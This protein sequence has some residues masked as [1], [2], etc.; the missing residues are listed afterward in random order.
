[1]SK[2][3]DDDIVA[4]LS[5]AAG[6][7]VGFGESRLS[8]E[9]EKV[10]KAYEGQTPERS[11]PGDSPY[12]SLDV[13]EAVESMRAQLL[14][15]ASAT[16]RPITFKPAMGEDPSAAET[17]TDWCNHVVFDLNEGFSLFQTILEDGLMNR[18]GIL[19]CYW[20]SI[21]KTETYDLTNTTME[22][23]QAHMAQDP[24]VEIEDYEI[25]S[26]GVAL[27]RVRLTKKSDRSQIRLEA[28]APEEFGIAPMAKD[29]KS[30]DCFHRRRMSINQL[31]DAGYDKD[32]VEALQSDERLWE[33]T[34]SDRY[35]RFAPTDDMIGD[36]STGGVGGKA[37]RKCMVTEGYTELDLDDTGESRLYKITWAGTTLLDK[38]PVERKPFLAFVPLPRSHAFWGSNYAQMVMQTQNARTYLTRSIINHGLITNNPRLAVVRGA[39]LNPRELMENRIGGIV[40][41]TRPDGIVPIPQQGLN[42]FIFQTIQLVGDDKEQLT[43]ISRL[44]QGLNK[45]A[46]S[47]QNSQGMVNDLVNLS[48]TRQKVIAR[49]FV[50]R[51]L[52][53]LYTQIYMLTL[54]NEDRKKIMEQ[55][56]Q[57]VDV[58][59][60]AWPEDANTEVNTSLGAAARQQEVQKWMVLDKTLSGDPGLAPMYPGAKRFAVIKRAMEASGIRNV[61]D[62]LLTPDQVPP[63][64]PSPMDLADLEVKKADAAVKR[65]NADAAVKSLELKTTVAADKKAEFYAKLQMAGHKDEVK[66]Q[67]EQDKLAH[68]VA[69]DAANL[70]LALQ[71]MEAGKL[72][73][74]VSLS[75]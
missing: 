55:S 19:K 64:Q 15:V 45:D 65:A 6:Q 34:D 17:R 70:R 21:S 42:P 60:T 38:E 51:F 58:D 33:G 32:K 50:E 27:K 71:E 37:Q 24:T 56:G 75:S 39:V 66:E 13:F 4:R 46:I 57:W 11:S 22:E 20:E 54:E 12:V 10:V 53:P 16:H 29:I 43:G 36:D 23:L 40:N 68:K 41:V 28:L 63:P 3:N 35:R 52:R 31:L 2:L 9:R 5:Y 26:D 59:F 44:S 67:L 69:D 14:E 61:T 8:K 73:A 47:S 62:Y 18:A 49:N 48:Q 72:T 7:A 30:A 1:M 25:H 74:S